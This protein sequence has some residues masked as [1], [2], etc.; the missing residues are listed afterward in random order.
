MGERLRTSTPS[1]RM[2]VSNLHIFTNPEALAP[3]LWG[4]LEASLHRLYWLNHWSLVDSTSN[5]SPLPK[6]QERWEW[7][8]QPPNH[9]VGSAG[10]QAPSLGGAQ[11]SPHLHNRRYLILL[12]TQETP[13]VLELCARNG[14]EDQIYVFFF[15]YQSQN[16]SHIPCS[17]DQIIL[18]V[19]FPKSLLKLKISSQLPFAY[20]FLQLSLTEAMR[21]FNF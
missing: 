6:C 20:S 1:L 17:Y 15:Y 3:V 7:K 18:L 4:V 19:S 21:T 13:K 11:I 10:N 12:I 14:D 8:F 16:Q 9:M 5:P 2:L